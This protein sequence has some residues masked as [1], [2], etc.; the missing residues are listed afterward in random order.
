MKKVRILLVEDRKSA[1]TTIKG[2]L[3]G[4]KYTIDEAKSGEEALERSF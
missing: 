4:L 2:M 3:R 1:R